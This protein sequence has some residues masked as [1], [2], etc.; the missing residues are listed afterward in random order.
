MMRVLPISEGRG[1]FQEWKERTRRAR[2]DKAMQSLGPKTRELLARGGNIDVAAS[3]YKLTG[4]RV[5]STKFP[6]AGIFPLT[7]S[8]LNRVADEQRKQGERI[9]KEAQGIVQINDGDEGGSLV[10]EVCSNEQDQEG[11]EGGAGGDDRETNGARLYSFSPRSRE[12]CRTKITEFFC[13][14]PSA[15]FTF[16][17][18]TFIAKVEH[19]LAQRVLQNFLSQVRLT[20]GNFEYVA[21]AEPQEENTEFPDNIHY[22]LIINKRL[23]VTRF[24]SLWVYEQYN[25]GLKGYSRQE[26]RYIEQEEINKRHW[27]LLRLIEQFKNAQTN[28]ERKEIKAD[29][30]LHKIG[31]LFNPFQI[32]K[33]K[34]ITGLGIYLTKYVT[35]NNAEF[36]VRVWSCSRRV[37]KLF[38][39]Q[40]CGW[41]MMQLAQS[42]FNM[43]VDKKTGELF[44]PRCITNRDAPGQED[45]PVFVVIVYLRNKNFFAKYLSKLRQVNKWIMNEGF[46]P[47]GDSLMR[48][49]YTD[50]LQHYHHIRYDANGTYNDEEK[51]WRTE[52]R[53]VN[54]L[55][56]LKKMRVN[57][58]PCEKVPVDI[59][60]FQL[61]PN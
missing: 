37:S 6:N 47:D 44:E 35:K 13:A 12:K 3:V 4:E 22:H 9:E 32:R 14:C 25:A 29:I 45:K 49:N 30:E 17:T 54:Y 21:V 58:Q 24:N 7:G 41:S 1:I 55:C 38:T 28:K 34:T 56:A 59:G 23:D 10:D 2:V 40:L 18:L 27:R 48:L 15:K 50:Y 11:I 39:G 42:K 57:Y 26:H 61:S 8:S 16:L 19:K 60:E 43:Y 20:K 33:I 51:D 31:K 46:I 5:V 36:Q 52:Q 53:R